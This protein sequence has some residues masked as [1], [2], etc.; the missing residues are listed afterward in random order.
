MGEEISKE[1]HGEIYGSTSNRSP[2]TLLGNLAG[3]PGGIAREISGRSTTNTLE[4]PYL[5]MLTDFIKEVPRNYRDEFQKK[6]G[7][8]PQDCDLVES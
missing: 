7:W 4:E 6:N 8:I 3:F 2:K 1:T 5:G